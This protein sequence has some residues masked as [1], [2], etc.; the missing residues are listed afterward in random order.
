[1][2]GEKKVIVRKESSDFFRKTV[3]Y[4][5][6]SDP[7]LA[8]E[9]ANI[10]R[11]GGDRGICVQAVVEIVDGG[12]KDEVGV[13]IVEICE[14]QLRDRDAWAVGCERRIHVGRMVGRRC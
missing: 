9:G 10:C 12:Y 7:F 1:M 5:C 8:G 14:C 2:R 4:Q 13:P 6:E 3:K 11:I